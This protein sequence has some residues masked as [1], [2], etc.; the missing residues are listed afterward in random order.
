[1]R[2]AKRAKVTRIT[3]TQ[4][5]RCV[6]SRAGASSFVLGMSRALRRVRKSRAPP[7][8]WPLPEKPELVQ[9]ERVILAE[10]EEQNRV[11][12]SLQRE[13]AGSA[14]RVALVD[15]PMA[16]GKSEFLRNVV[17]RAQR[18]GFLALTAHCSRTERTLPG[19]VL[20]QLV[21]GIDNRYTRL[22]DAG[23]LDSA[24]AL[25]EHDEIASELLRVFRE[26]CS[27]VLD[28]ARDTPLL[29]AVDDAH[30]MDQGSATW[31]LQLLRRSQS[32]RVLVVLTADTR[33]PA[34]PW[35]LHSELVRQPHFR[36]IELAPLSAAGVGEVVSQRAGDL[37]AQR[38]TADFTAASGGNPLLL[39]AL[40]DD[41]LAGR[42]AQHHD[43]ALLSCLQRG[44]PFMSEVAR[45]VAVLGQDA[46][47]GT[48][49]A[50]TE[51]DA[52]RVGH[53]L[54]ALT[55]AGLL[56]DGAFRSPQ[57]VAA[58]LATAQ[59]R[60][61][62]HHRAARLLH[63]GGSPVSAV[64]RH[65]VQAEGAS[66][67][68]ARNV[69]REAA[70][71]ALLEGEPRLAIECL[72]L[73]HGSCG[74]ESER[75]AIRARLAE[76]EWRT[77]PGSVL[78][79]LGPLAAAADAGRLDGS[80][81][82]ALVRRLLWHGRVDEAR[83]VLDNLR[84]ARRQKPD[85]PAVESRDVELWLGYAHPPLAAGAQRS[86]RWSRPG[87]FAT[88]SG[89]PWLHT[90]ANLADVLVRGQSAKAVEQA[91][92]ALRDV[93]RTRGTM[94]CEEATM[95]AL[96]VL[97]QGG[98]IALACDWCRKLA[99]AT[100]SHQTPAL[101]A[102]IAS[103]RSE[104]LL[105]GGEFRASIEQAGVALRHLTPQAWGVAVGLPLSALVLAHT[106]LGEHDE[107]AR[108][109]VHQ[110]DD[111]MFHSRYGL[112]YLYARGHH[113]LATAHPYAALADF[114]ACRD[115]TNDWGL[116]RAGLV[117]WRTG[118]AEAWLQL[119]NTDEARRLA[120]DELAQPGPE[121]ARSRGAALRLL[122]ATNAPRR[123]PQLL[124]EALELL[125]KCGD[126]YEQARVLTDL[127]EAHH[128]L[129]DNRRARPI[130]RRAWHL[131]GLCGA[132]SL[133]ERLL[134]V[135]GDATR[136]HL[137]AGEG[138]ISSLTDSER[139]VASLAVMGYTNREIAE[140]LFVTAST[141]EQHLTRVFRK[142][143]VKRRAELPVELWSATAR[144]A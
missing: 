33:L 24:I 102:I 47:T 92:R 103:V 112:H 139:R 116:S 140:K 88:S 142:L 11:V 130:F 56:R 2:A 61:L 108:H 121:Q 98:R 62:M 96:V 58:V 131:A 95:L 66:E 21:R 41:H 42:T 133:Q 144:S 129:N 19:G 53:V 90:T 94:W 9:G 40:I 10:R 114:T 43:L 1:M 120:Y 100:S 81:R 126:R 4:N 46:T 109:L 127:S 106:R 8:A 3:L 84:R 35:P 18:A 23:L 128:E 60:A 91:E 101:R 49:A 125:E 26:L 45:A 132:A 54:Q 37:A 39:H 27:A 83:Q 22:L 14:G 93:Y 34:V 79:H 74:Q 15:G 122:A 68:W 115:L 55:A 44:G 87:G 30:H 65:L 50:L 70:E 7:P 119:G 137:V 72:E 135:S 38:L 104:L 76:A 86:A 28:R 117:P 105:R 5:R 141:V 97:V 85:D 64:A 20:S 107:A 63:E 99:A 89:D 73:A 75:A 71:V 57:A 67:S 111:A 113:H 48:V 6:N 32:S 31:L 78:P 59:N 134:A 110:V 29:L 80:D 69:L 16:C 12:G 124:N 25:V 13:S 123:R 143:Q 52:D 82:A 17:E 77:S 138:R 136:G 36:R 51:S 118:A